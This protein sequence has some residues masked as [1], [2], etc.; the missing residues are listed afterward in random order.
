MLA[1][2]RLSRTMSTAASH[3]NLNGYLAQKKQ[4]WLDEARHAEPKQ[5]L[6][7]C[8]VKSRSGVREIRI[9]D[10][11]IIADSGPGM[12]GYDL[13]ASAQSVSRN[14]LCEQ[15]DKTSGRSCSEAYGYP[16]FPAE[17]NFVLWKLAAWCGFPYS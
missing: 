5:M 6:A 15:A 11:Q 8:S 9:R 12:A 14:P 1:I 16:L 2:R 7:K 4:L 17:A 10:H 3:S 13:G